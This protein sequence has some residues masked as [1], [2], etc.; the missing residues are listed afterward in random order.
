MNTIR[1]LLCLSVF[2]GTAVQAKSKFIAHA[3][4]SATVKTRN[5][6]KESFGLQLQRIAQIQADL[7][8][9]VGLFMMRQATL[10]Q[11]V[12]RQ[13]GNLI[14]DKPPFDSVGTSRLSRAVSASHEKTM[15]LQELLAQVNEVNDELLSIV[16]LEDDSSSS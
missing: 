11:V 1:M 8:H 15:Q 14:A 4:R 7:Q 9:Q 13:G 5:E 16:R 2:M 12:V 6:E 10:Q 3:K